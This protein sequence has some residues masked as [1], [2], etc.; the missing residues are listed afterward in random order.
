MA[1]KA[2]EAVENESRSFESFGIGEAQDAVSKSGEVMVAIDVVGLLSISLVHLTVKFQNQA[3]L[4][5]V[6]V[7][8]IAA[9]RYL[10]TELE[11]EKPSIPEQIP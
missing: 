7:R 10:T 3:H 5:A 1:E 6:E 9:D 8:D 2:E 4:V 11:P